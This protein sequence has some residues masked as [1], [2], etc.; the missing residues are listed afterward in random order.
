[1]RCLVYVGIPTTTI[2]HQPNVGTVNI[3]YMA[4]SIFTWKPQ[5]LRDGGATNGGKT[6]GKLG[7]NKE[8]MLE[9]HG[10]SK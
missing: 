2:K 10:M 8:E 9:L 4:P 1:M 6:W 5:V 3:P 7:G